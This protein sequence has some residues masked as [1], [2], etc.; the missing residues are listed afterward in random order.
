MK[1][2]ALRILREDQNQEI[3]WFE[4]S[5]GVSGV[6]FKK[7]GCNESHYDLVN[8]FPIEAGELNIQFKEGSVGALSLTG[9]VAEICDDGVF[10][11]EVNGF[12]FWVSQEEYGAKIEK[13]QLFNMSLKNF[14]LYI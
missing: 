12:D 2:P 5:S 13:G 10:C 9:M 8:I 4:S 3:V 14:T 6:A 11:I 7:N 1:I